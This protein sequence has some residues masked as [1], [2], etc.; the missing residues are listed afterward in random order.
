[1]TTSGRRQHNS[2]RTENSGRGERSPERTGGPERPLRWL[3]LGLVWGALTPS[4]LLAPALL[5]QNAPPAKSQS[6]TAQPTAQPT[7]QPGQPAAT[8]AANQKAGLEGRVLREAQPVSAVRVY[9]YEV[10]SFRMHQVET[11]KTGAFR[12]RDLPAGMYKLVAFKPGFVPTVELLLRQSAELAQKIELQLREE[13]L[14]GGVHGED[15]WTVRGRVPVDVL[16]QIQATGLEKVATGS[17]LQLRGSDLFAAEMQ[18]LSGV[19]QLGAGGEASLTSAEFGVRGAIGQ[20]KIGVDGSYQ[21]LATQAGTQ[22][23]AVRSIALDVQKAQDQKLRLHGSSGEIEGAGAPVGLDQYQIDWQGRTGRKGETRVSASFTEQQNYHLSGWLDPDQIPWSS[24]SFAVDGSYSHRLGATDLEAGASYHQNSLENGVSF[25]PIDEERLGLYGNASTQVGPRVLVEYGFYSS[26]RDGSLSLTPHG[27][28]VITLNGDWQGRAAFSQ[29]VEQRGEAYFQGFSS[30][31]YG[32]R[33]SCRTVTEACYQ[34]SFTR[35]E[36][37]NQ[38]SL[39]AIQRRFAETL[40]LYF[41][42]DFFDRLESVFV[43]EG[44]QLPELQFS[45]TRRLAPRILAKLESNLAE[46]GGGIFYATDEQPYKNDV[47]Y[48]VTSL[49][50]RFQRTATGVFV[51]FHHLQQSFK[52]VGGETEEQQAHLEVERLQLMLTQDLNVL[53]DLASNWAVRLNMELSRGSTPYTLS[54][55]NE[56]YKKLTGGISVSF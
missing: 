46:G 34:V 32:D 51:A 49:D 37:D 33:D 20:V 1:M 55:D 14:E 31:F 6:V 9:A 25:Q 26:V 39:G 48:L 40:R 36:E 30:A 38:V 24:Q 3:R 45:V 41:S 42:P 12:F 54:V 11:D 56:L 10:A 47:R 5:A 29:R 43:V 17:S 27:G 4:F 7:S 28:V 44:D 52:K 2:V 16:R 23:G 19:E 18:A 53:V 50:T 22:A 35:G 21:G 13:Q 8:V 15:Y